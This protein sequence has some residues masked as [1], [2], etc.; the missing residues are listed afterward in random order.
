[1]FYLDVSDEL[2]SRGFYG[3]LTVYDSLYGSCPP[4]GLIQHLG[5]EAVRVLPPVH[6]DVP[7]TCKMRR[8]VANVKAEL[9]N[10]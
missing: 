9:Y 8:Q 2:Q 6:N 5:V 4:H 10:M 7:V 3:G 1:M